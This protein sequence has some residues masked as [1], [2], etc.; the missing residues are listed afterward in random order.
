MHAKVIPLMEMVPSLECSKKIILNSG[1]F[2]DG[3]KITIC[4]DATHSD[5]GESY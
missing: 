4:T 2:K 1:Y 3:K 5:H